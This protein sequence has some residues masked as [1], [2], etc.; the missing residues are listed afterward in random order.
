MPK[1]P[2]E[3]RVLLDEQIQ[4]YRQR[5][6]EYDAWFRRKGPWNQG[7]EHKREWDA[8]VAQLESAIDRA[9]P[10]GRILELACGTGIWTQR[11]APL[12]EHLTAVDTSPE[13]LEL[14]RRRVGLDRVEYVQR[15]IF[16][17]IPEETYDFIFFGFWL[18]HVP[19]R[20]FDR[21][22]ELLGTALRPGGSVFFLDTLFQRDAIVRV[23]REEDLEV[24][25]LIDGRR[26]R[27]I[28]VFFEADSLQKRLKSLGWDGYVRSTNRYFIY[29][30]QQ[31][32]V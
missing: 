6:P 18:S 2:S 15:D 3:E 8:E 27:I 4:Y 5:A 17:W 29:G 10:H 16:R 9:Q 13:V 30:L 7:Y 32:D 23:S 14:N 11:L 19:P 24:R 1:E 25:Q 12:S 21:F 28:K 31:P 20:R 22:W 26:F